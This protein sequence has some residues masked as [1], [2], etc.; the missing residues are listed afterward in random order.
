MINEPFP[1]F[2]VLS[3][4]IFFPVLSFEKFDILIWKYID[5]PNRSNITF[6][7]NSLSKENCEGGE[8]LE[9]QTKGVLFVCISLFVFK[10]IEVKLTVLYFSYSF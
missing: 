2:T 4:K 10:S 9:S 8:E 1:Y 7:T 3:I 6:C 5:L